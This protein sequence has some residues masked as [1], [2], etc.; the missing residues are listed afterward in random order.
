MIETG[1]LLL[2]P[3]TAADRAMLHAMWADP[4]VMAD[5]GP[6]KSP[7]DSDATIARHAAY[8]VRRG[9]GFHVVE[10]REGREP[11][12]FCGL[13][14]GAEGT[15]IEGEIEIGWSLARPWWEKG[16]AFEAAS[17]CLDWAWVNTPALR[18]AAITAAR[19]LRSQILMERLGMVRQ[20]DDDFF[21]HL[22]APDD[23]LGQSVVFA[24]HRPGDTA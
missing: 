24:I 16:Y 23:P 9:F 15:P 6:V 2:R 12:G 21:H 5:L 3:P 22:F 10:L 17:A 14:P 11:I 8:G 18:V 1:R 13:K 4:V 7:E 20:P 19:N